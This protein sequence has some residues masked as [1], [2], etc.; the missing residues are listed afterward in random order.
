[1]N[2]NMVYDQFSKDYDRFVNW[3]ARLST[4]MPFLISELSS[5]EL[6]GKDEVTILDA[7]CG[8][9]H[10]VIALSKAGFKCSGADISAGM[11]ELAQKNAERENQNIDFKQ[12]GFGQLTLVFKQNT[13]HGL[14]CLGNS[15]PHVVDDEALS[16][17]LDDFRLVLSPGGKLIIQNRNFDLVMAERERWMT[18]QTYREGEKTWLFNRFYDFEPDGHVAFNIMIMFAEGSDEFQQHVISTRLW[19][20]KMEKLV[21]ILDKSGFEA[22]QLFGDL[23]GSLFEIEKSGNLVITARAR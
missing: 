14:I 2:N 19:P 20:L 8:T 11:V 17:A 5:I 16:E 1:M 10:H 22:I 18:P 9:G 7:A 4:E 23:Q 3:N 6:C 12:A 13:F 15:L 21:N